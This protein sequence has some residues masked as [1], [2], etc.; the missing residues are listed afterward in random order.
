MRRGR[1]VAGGAARSLSLAGRGAR[2]GGAVRL[3]AVRR[4]GGRHL[5]AD[6]RQPRAPQH[7]GDLRLGPWARSPADRGALHAPDGSGWRVA[8]QLR[9]HRRLAHLGGA[10]PR[11]LHGQPDRAE[12]LHACGAG[13]CQARP[14]GS[15]PSGSPCT[16]RAPRPRR[17][18]FAA[19]VRKMV[20]EQVGIFGETARYD[21]QVYTFLADYL[22]GP[23][24]TAWSTATPPCSAPRARWRRTSTGCSSPRRTSSSTPGTWSG[25]GR[26]RSSRSISPGPIRRTRSGSGR[27]S[28]TTSTGSVLRRAG[29]LSDSVFAGHGG[30]HRQRRRP[31]SG[32]SVPQP[33]GDEPAGAVRGRGH[34]DRSRPTSRTPSSPI[35]P[36][37][38]AS[39][40]AWI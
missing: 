18:R 10:G 12:R 2:T 24:A 40:S 23:R 1:R 7:A 31:R 14:G 5:F 19:A 15:T 39:R 25:S 27:G 8:T 13:P 29:L 20:A 33:D 6:R 38:R 28:P 35:T 36:G 3:H 4:P 34:R 17:I 11:I 37:A 30:E 9:R 32:P 21:H 16:T 26:R 22:P